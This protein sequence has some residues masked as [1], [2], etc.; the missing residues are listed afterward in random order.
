MGH[1]ISSE[2]AS[3][4]PDKIKAVRDYP[5]PTTLKELRQFLGLVNYYRRFV[6]KFASIA[7]PLYKL[8]RKGIP[9][10]WT[11]ACQGA[12]DRLKQALSS[13]PIL[14]YPHFDVPFTVFTD[15][16][17]WAVGAVLAQIQDG[18][19]HV[20]AYYSRQ[21]SKQERNYST[22]ER[23]ALA[24]VAA[25]K[26]FYPY[27]YGREFQLVTDHNPLVTLTNLKDVT[28]RLARWIMYLQQFNYSFI[29][30]SGKSHANADSLSRSSPPHN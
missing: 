2:G 30:R 6:K 27:L 12:L 25:V 26:E 11:S 5:T 28:G 17:N 29:H 20:V 10:K 8:I 15:A 23:E 13:P 3:P 7:E 21:L 16:S 19:E 14:S 18:E 24:V 4:D 1:I 22:M 9:F